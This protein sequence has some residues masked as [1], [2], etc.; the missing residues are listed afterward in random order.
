M[1]ESRPYDRAR[2]GDGGSTMLRRMLLIVFWIATGLVVNGCTK[3]G[4]VWD[5]WMPGPKSCRSDH[6]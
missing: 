6:I 5:D 4:P 3:C 2:S 1:P